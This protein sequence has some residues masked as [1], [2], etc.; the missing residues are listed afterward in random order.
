MKSVSGRSVVG[1]AVMAV[2]K[3][4]LSALK[5][6]GTVSLLSKARR[7]CS[8]ILVSSACTFDESGVVPR[9][10]ITVTS[11]AARLDRLSAMTFE[12]RNVLPAPERP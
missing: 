4:S 8:Q 9:K 11:P 6:P 3:Y 7:S 12:R 1:H 2:R 10:R 5:S